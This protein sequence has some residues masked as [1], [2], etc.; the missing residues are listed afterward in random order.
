[1]ATIL[2][3]LSVIPAANAQYYSYSGH[4]SVS[5]GTNGVIYK[6]QYWVNTEGY[7]SD[8]YHKYRHWNYIGW[9]NVTT[10]IG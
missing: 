9:H 10:Y 3:S 2:I 6:S 7:G 8:H 1:M 4:G 5:Y